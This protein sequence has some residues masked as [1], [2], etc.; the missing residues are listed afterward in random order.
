MS[1]PFNH[2]E[3]NRSP[4]LRNEH[5][6]HIGMATLAILLVGGIYSVRCTIA[7]NVQLLTFDIQDCE[8][9]QESETELMESI[10]NLD[11]RKRELEEEYR[12]LM[13]RIPK[14]IADSEVLSVVRQSLQNTRCNLIDFRP[15]ITQ[16]NSEYQTR[17]YDLQLEGSFKN[18]FQLFRTLREAS[19]A[20]Q[21]S[22]LKIS[23]PVTPG[24][25]CHL[26]LELKVIFDHSCT[27][28]E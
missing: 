19:L 22:R 27:P 11:L 3:A 6:L 13:V 16:Q 28:S 9:L 23:E 20:F 24:G 26:D 1:S 8:S 12:S 5:L 21:T 17:S 10:A 7:E 18:I 14:K 4:A 25:P 15:T 2:R